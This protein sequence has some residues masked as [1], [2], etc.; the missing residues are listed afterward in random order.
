MG[1]GIDI[2][3]AGNG[4]RGTV[5]GPEGGRCREHK[6][7]WDI[8]KLTDIDSAYS[9]SLSSPDSLRSLQDE[10]RLVCTMSSKMLHAFAMTSDDRH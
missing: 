2:A 1:I 4:G 3:M 8:G 5:R 6:D 7:L 10:C 9:N